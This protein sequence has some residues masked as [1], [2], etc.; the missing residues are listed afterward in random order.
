MSWIHC[1]P[2]LLRT[3]LAD[4]EISALNETAVESNQ[5]LQEEC[6]N[7]CEAWRGRIKKF[8]SIDRREDFV[9]S[10]LL[11]FILVHIRYNSFTRLPQMESLLDKLRQEE[12][13]RA[14]AIFDDPELIEIDEP[15]EPE[16][17]SNG[18]VI[19]VNPRN[20]ILD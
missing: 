1:T 4:S 16:E 17:S 7:V 10:Q 11:T 14:N 9:P 13:R 2:D 3:T 12:W 19:E 15:E 20:F 18:P 5:I 6:H 8:H